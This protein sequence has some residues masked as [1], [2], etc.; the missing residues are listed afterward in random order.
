M[1]RV[2]FNLLCAFSF[3]L[4]VGTILLWLR[5]HGPGDVF[6]VESYRITDQRVRPNANPEADIRHLHLVSRRNRL[7]LDWYH[8]SPKEAASMSIDYWRKN[9]PSP[10]EL[11]WLDLHSTVRGLP[12]DPPTRLSEMGF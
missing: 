7:A 5:S 2:V 4:W 10:Y 12:R 1:L 8:W 9:H 3:L 6:G 11:V